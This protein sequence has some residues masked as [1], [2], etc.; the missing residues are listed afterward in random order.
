MD[1]IKS[2]IE[3]VISVVVLL[4]IINFLYPDLMGGVLSSGGLGGGPAV[5]F[6]GKP[7]ISYQTTS[8]NDDTR[9]YEYEIIFS[10]EVEYSGKMEEFGRSI[11]LIEVVPVI[12][13][14]G[15]SQKANVSGD[16][17][18][19]SD[20]IRFK[21]TNDDKKFIGEFS[22][23]IS[24][25]LPPLR[26]VKDQTTGE[27]KNTYDGWMEKSDN[28]ILTSEEG[29]NLTIMIS[30]VKKYTYGLPLIKY[31]PGQSETRCEASIS[32]SCGESASLRLRGMNDCGND[33]NDCERYLN[34]CNG[35]VHIR[36]DEVDCGNKKV[37]IFIEFTGGMD[38]D[39][40]D[41]IGISFWKNSKCVRDHPSYDSLLASCLES[42]F[43]GRSVFRKMIETN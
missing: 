17:D 32:I 18:K 19:V 26:I 27:P 15:K 38:Y 20:N 35:A 41:D 31:I 8:I 21:I 5:K 25:S 29:H 1:I 42:D 30:E 2:L 10:G 23:V 24:S 4:L 14:K 37:D 12:D 39:A 13:L 34:M 28:F 22:A 36:A 7:E 11:S 9:R 3:I 40:G 6:L 33:K 16:V 43:L